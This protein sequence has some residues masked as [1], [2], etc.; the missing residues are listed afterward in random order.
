MSDPGKKH[1]GTDAGTPATPPDRRGGGTGIAGG[2]DLHAMALVLAAI[3][4][5]RGSKLGWLDKIANDVPV[6]VTA[7]TGGSGDDIGLELEDGTR[8][9]VQSKK[10]LQRGA[11]LWTALENLIDGVFRQGGRPGRAGRIHRQQ[12]DGSPGPSGRPRPY[13]AG[14]VRDAHRHR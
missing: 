7:E 9:E 2:T 1:V 5:M 3:A 8:V 11:E 12:P 13:R 10:G 6:A 14:T 4:L